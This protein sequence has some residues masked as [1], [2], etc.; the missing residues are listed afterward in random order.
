[1]YTFIVTLCAAVASMWSGFDG[2]CRR[3][4]AL[5]AER[6]M[7][8]CLDNPRGCTEARP[9]SQSIAF[10]NVLRIIKSM[11]LTPP[12]TFATASRLAVL[13]FA[14]IVGSRQLKPNLGDS[15]NSALLRQPDKSEVDHVH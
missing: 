8:A 7:G 12:G 13:L 2:F 14:D 1:V 10:C 6:V 5:P 11:P 9:A 4:V 15:V 3:R